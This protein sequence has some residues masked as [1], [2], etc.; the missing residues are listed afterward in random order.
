MCG[1]LLSMLQRPAVLQVGSD[2][3]HAKRVT[4]GGVGQGGAGR[5]P[6]DHRQNIF[7]RH[8]IFGK[9]VP[10]PDRAEERSLLIARDLCR[11]YPRVQVFGEIMMARHLVALAAFLM[12]AQ[13]GPFA[14]LEG[15]RLRPTGR[16]SAKSR[17]V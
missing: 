2:A 4:T 17:L 1:D 7:S 5:A 11:Q 9:F 10:F 14:V 3:G 8:R 13:P 16:R 15:L 6:L 12:Q